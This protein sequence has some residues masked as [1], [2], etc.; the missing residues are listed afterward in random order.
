MT[1]AVGIVMV[2]QITLLIAKAHFNVMKRLTKKL[3][4]GTLSFLLQRVVLI[5]FL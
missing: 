4:L 5:W 1:Q 2:H 3:G